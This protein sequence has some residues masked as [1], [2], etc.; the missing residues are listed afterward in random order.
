MNGKDPSAGDAHRSLCSL[1][2]GLFQATVNKLEL[3]EKV[4]CGQPVR[5]FR[6]G[7]DTPK[8]HSTNPAGKPDGGSC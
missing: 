2:R 8:L 7:G 3:R 4:V 5:Y 6:I 1:A